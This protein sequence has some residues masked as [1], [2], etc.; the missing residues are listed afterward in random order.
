MDSLRC[1]VAEQA[2]RHSAAKTQVKIK[3]A[4]LAPKQNTSGNPGA[5]VD[6]IQPAKGF[7]SRCTASARSKYCATLGAYVVCEFSK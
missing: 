1:T 4:A 5:T 2:V 3:E 6:Q 7:A